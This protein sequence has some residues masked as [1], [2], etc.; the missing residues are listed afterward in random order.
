MEAEDVAQEIAVVRA[1][2]RREPQPPD[3]PSVAVEGDALMVDRWWPAALWVA[4]STCLVRVDDCPLPE[5]LGAV[6]TALGEVGLKMVDVGL[7]API[8]AISVGRLG[9]LGADWHVWSSDV[10]SA[11]AAIADAASG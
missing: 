1:F 9:V 3:A 7:A 4:S 10:D 5:V 6:A 8:Q 2:A 11:R